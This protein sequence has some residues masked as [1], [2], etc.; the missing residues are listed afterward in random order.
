MSELTQ[1]SVI[2]LNRFEARMR[3]YGAKGPGL[4]RVTYNAPKGKFFV[5][6]LLGVED[7]SG[8]DRMNAN[9]VLEEMGWKF[10][11]E[12]AGER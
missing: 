8:K 7:R 6:M 5:V 3:Y 10:E 11:V 9:K 2:R 1:G 12:D 4:E